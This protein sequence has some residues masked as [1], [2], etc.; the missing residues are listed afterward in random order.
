MKSLYTILT[1]ILCLSIKAQN[2]STSVKEE[3]NKPKTEVM[4]LIKGETFGN[5]VD[6]DDP[7]EILFK[8]D[9]NEDVIIGFVPENA[10]K[11][12]SDLKDENGKIVTTFGQI[13]KEYLNKKYKITYELKKVKVM[14]PNTFVNDIELDAKVVSKMV[15]IK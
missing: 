15:L 13:Q 5:R 9:K 7:G 2:N 8:N 12:L 4:T 11:C 6:T 10:I 1:L 3:Y 14:N